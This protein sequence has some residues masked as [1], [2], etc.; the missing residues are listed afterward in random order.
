MAKPNRPKLKAITVRLD[1]D[2]VDRA[3]EWCRDQAGR[4][5]YLTLSALV[6]AGIEREIQRQALILSG[7][8]PL[9]RATGKPEESDDEPP[10]PTSPVRRRINAS[11]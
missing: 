2:L 8:L 5:L 9:E 6:A 4:P 7:A 3:R 10:P 1:A 11:R